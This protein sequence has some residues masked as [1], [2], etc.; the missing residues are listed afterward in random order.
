[1]ISEFL[2]LL[3]LRAKNFKN[4]IFSK[5]F[6]KNFWVPFSLGIF[7]FFVLFLIFTRVFSFL[8]SIPVIG[9]IISFKFLDFTLMGIF[10]FLALSNIVGS[11]SLI[12][13]DIE[14]DFLNKFPIKKETLY[15]F[16]FFEIL[17]YSSWVP[18]IFLLPFL[19]SFINSFPPAKGNLFFLPINFI[20]YLISASLTGILLFYLFMKFTP[21]V[22]REFIPVFFGF[23]FFIFIFIYLKYVNPGVFKVFN[24]KSLKEAVLI[25]KK[26][27]SLSPFFIPSNWL[28]ANI[29]STKN[30]LLITF[31]FLFYNILLFLILI[32]LPF[33]NLY[34]KTYIS[35][36]SKGGRRFKF[37]LLQKEL[38][39]FYRNYSQLSQFI[40][41]LLLFVLY[42]IS[43][44]GKGIR[45][46]H[47]IWHIL[48]AYANFTFTLYLL[49]TIAVR[50]IYTAPSLENKG[51]Q[52]LYYSPS[53]PFNLFK[54]QFLFYFSMVFILGILI[55]FL[56]HF[57]LKVQ[58]FKNQTFY[59]ILSIPVMCFNIAFLALCIGYILPQF[60]ETNPA[61]IASG[62]GAFL[63]AMVLIIYLI[64]GVYILIQTPFRKFYYGESISFFAMF[65]IFVSLSVFLGLIFFKFLFDKIK[66]MEF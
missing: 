2:L 55:F 26:A 3:N 12:F 64:T 33:Q 47:P 18:L 65:L 22:K 31:L 59:M 50:F 39:N 45:I 44:R 27:G 10:F 19:F 24:A 1:M 8:S 36:G 14:L 63:T 46:T 20:L 30:P 41:L 43:I 40:F 49:I 38:K 66:K 16:K 54:T 61:K 37:I 13:E 58:F 34:H 5:E 48:I 56:T 51:L 11:F 9:E 17:L 7:L 15:S 60:N 25:L 23:L 53:N 6:W 28:T 35:K 42:I 4:L 32:N 57:S 29:L 62:P 21:M 52:I